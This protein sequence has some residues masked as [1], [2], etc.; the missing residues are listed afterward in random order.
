MIRIVMLTSVVMLGLCSDATAGGF[1][2]GRFQ[3]KHPAPVAPMFVP[4]ECP[5]IVQC[6]PCLPIVSEPVRPSEKPNLIEVPEFPAPP[7]L[8]KDFK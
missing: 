3:A 7:K 2:R 4:P 8:P 5:A 1:L 6:S